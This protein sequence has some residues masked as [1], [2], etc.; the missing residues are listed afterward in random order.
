[1][2]DHNKCGSHIVVARRYYNS[3]LNNNK[4]K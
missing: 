1:M 3:A 2:L 4:E